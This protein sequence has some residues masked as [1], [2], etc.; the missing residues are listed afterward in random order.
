MSADAPAPPLRSLA[1]ARS[2]RRARRSYRPPPGGSP[3]KR[4]SRRGDDARHPQARVRAWAHARRGAGPDARA[5][6]GA[7]RV[8][9]RR[10]SAERTSTSSAGISGRPER[11]KPPLT[12][13]HEL[14][15]TRRRDGKRRPRRRRGRLRLGREPRH[16]RRV[17]PLPDRQGAHV[18]A[19][20]HPRCRPRRRVRRLRVR[21]RESVVWR[22]DR[23]KLPPEIAC[24]QEPFGNA[25]FADVDAG[26]RRTRAVA[27]ARVRATSASSR[28]R[29]RRPSVRGRLFASDHVPFRIE[30][31]R[32]AR[33][34]RRR[35]RRRGRR[36]SVRGS[37]SSNGGVGV[38]VVFEMSGALRAIEDA[39]GIVRHGGNVVLFGIP[40]RPA[41]IDIAE[42]LIF[43]N[44]TVTAVNGREI[45][46]TW[47]TT[48]WLLEHGVVDLRPLITAELPLEALRGG[49]RAAR[50]GRGLQDR[51][52]TERSDAVSATLDQQLGAELDALR[53]APDVQAASSRSESPQGPVVRMDG[54]GEVIVLSSNNYLGL[55]GHPEVVRAGIEGLRAY[56][57]GTASVRFICGTFEPHL[58]LERALADLSGTEAALTYVSCWNANEAVH[59]EPHGR[60]HGDPH[61]RAQPREPHRRDP[62][63]R[64]R[65]E[66]S[67]YPHSDMDCAAA[68]G[69][70]RR[71]RDARKLIV[72]DG[73]FSMEGDLAKLP[74]IVELAREHDAVVD[75]RRLARRRRARRDRARDGRSTSACSARSTSSR[76]ARQ[77]AR[78]RRRRLRRGVG[79]GLRRPR[80]ALAAA[81]LLERACRRPSRAAR[82]ARSSSCSSSR[83]SSPDC[84]R[85]RGV[86]RAARRGRLSTA[87]RRGGD[88]PD[89]HRRDRRGDGAV[90]AP[91]RRGR[92][93]HG[94][95]L[96]GRAGGNGTRA[97]SDVG[98]ARA[99]HLDA[100]GVEARS[101]L[102]DAQ[103]GRDRPNRGRGR[104]PYLPK[105][106]PWT[107]WPVN[108]VG[109]GLIVAG[110]LF[111]YFLNFVGIII[112]LIHGHRRDH[113][114]C[115]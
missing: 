71:S 22:N 93:R 11:V 15:G 91:A 10:P 6:R 37:S 68:T 104:S 30:L 55:A 109:L 64:A 38:G 89:H 47:Y 107:S 83:S 75:R 41:T 27:G 97:R 88:R 96:P 85:T 101:A 50:V 66:R 61:G 3:G 111:A 16:L 113:G 115:G 84:A 57:A 79:G 86:P 43:K 90:G 53:E 67:I 20:A 5:G 80:A 26:P 114:A 1:R 58:A 21:A 12:L 9:R 74:E 34:G 78:R 18:R 36:T 2:C 105:M 72:T 52:A 99:E 82:C 94:V 25:V 29:S 7:R 40:S 110:I 73:V 69:S 65:V 56:G 59:P 17:L 35:E 54:R 103:T 13:G 77:G 87:R 24:L 4:S 49:V 14:C 106:R 112:G 33:R 19:D 102:D 108:I 42:S 70:R 46:E 92:L 23:S 63:R 81:A 95:R 8:S 98:G 31:A 60:D 45:W 51:P 44:L 48:R 100:R 28:S 32:E 39:F 62:A 76:D